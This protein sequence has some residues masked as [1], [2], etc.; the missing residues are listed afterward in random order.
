MSIPLPTNGD[1]RLPLTC[2]CGIV[3]QVSLPVGETINSG[4]FSMLMAV[5]PKCVICPHCGQAYVPIIERVV[6]SWG[7]QPITEDQRKQ[8]EGSAVIVP[9]VHGVLP[10]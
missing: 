3:F 7:M 8:I 9:G 5:H 1:G 6:T 4:K 10:K 2:P